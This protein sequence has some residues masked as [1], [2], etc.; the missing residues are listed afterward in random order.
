METLLGTD[1]SNRVGLL[2]GKEFGWSVGVS[3]GVS[4][5]KKFLS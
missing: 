1:A 5:E 4:I 3:V 2:Y